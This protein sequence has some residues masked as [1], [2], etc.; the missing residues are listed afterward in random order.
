[1]REA[2]R[3]INHGEPSGIGRR[4][5]VLGFIATLF[6]CPLFFPSVA[7][8][9]SPY[10]RIED[11]NPVIATDGVGHWVCAWSAH[12]V[13]NDEYWG[14]CTFLAAYSSNDG[15]SWSRPECVNTGCI[16]TAHNTLATDCRGTWALIANRIAPSGS[17]NVGA[18]LDLSVSTNGGRTWL[19]RDLYIG[20]RLGAHA[21]FG[22]PAICLSSAGTWVLAWMTRALDQQGRPSDANPTQRLLVM[23]ST[24]GGA[25]WQSP[26]V[27]EE[28]HERWAQIDKPPAL[29]T[30]GR[31][32]WILAWSR[33]YRLGNDTRDDDIFCS[34]STDN[35]VT[36]SSPAPLNAD[37]ATDS[38]PDW[39]G[40]FPA[41]ADMG[42]RLTTDGHGVWLATWTRVKLEYNDEGMWSGPFEL[43]HSF[44]SDNG[45]TWSTPR[46]LSERHKREFAFHQLPSCVDIAPGKFA[47]A[48][49]V[50][51][52]RQLGNDSDI[53]CAYT[54]EATTRQF[55]TGCANTGA[56]TDWAWDG[57]PTI[58]AGK[59]GHCVAA[60]SSTNSLGKTIGKDA[61]ILFAHSYGGGKGWT[62]PKP[63]N[64]TAYTDQSP[65]SP[66]GRE[67]PP[68]VVTDG[69]SYWLSVWASTNDLDETIG[70]DWDILYS[71][72]QDNSTWSAA[73]ALNSDA[74][75]DGMSDWRPILVLG[76]TGTCIV[77]WQRESTVCISR[78]SDQGHSWS[79][80]T[81][82]ENP[83][84][85]EDFGVLDISLTCDGAG[86]WLVVWEMSGYESHEGFAYSASS[87][88]GSTWTSPKNLDARI[89]HKFG[90][91]SSYAVGMGPGGTWIVAVE[92]HKLTITATS[93]AG[94]SWSDA[95]EIGQDEGRYPNRIKFEKPV[96][97]RE[98]RWELYWGR[99]EGARIDE[100]RMSFSTDGGLTW[101]APE[102]VSLSAR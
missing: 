90:P 98:G 22:Q 59:D 27:I 42:V 55:G 47:V 35:A 18:G 80:P 87:D 65:L 61:D 21:E 92:N 99:G 53:L 81:V 62:N 86:A 43:F 50:S 3:T 67:K 78:S 8:A 71:Y 15:Q 89:T 44:S 60:W 4:L 97:V 101:S 70:E 20:E 77:A 40:D 39:S 6:L 56:T 45:A 10:T 36:W 69:Q 76:N 51:S 7:V 46:R 25:N 48:W 16:E 88:D 32:T 84:G 34:I 26:T 13:E 9:D 19:N 96:T 5:S 73:R 102:N 64:S 52:S 94:G 85:A 49:Q 28:S 93:N 58:A 41:D 17:S 31:G 12:C 24:D 72:S 79:K 11:R 95:V 33:I 14:E 74:A 30:D 91:P 66:P 37:A 1:M 29:A 83:A 100:R 82:L 23:L 2:F 63:L 75:V 54:Q 38:V 57:Q 68:H